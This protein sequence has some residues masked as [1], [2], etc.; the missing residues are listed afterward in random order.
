MQDGS[1]MPNDRLHK[2][3]YTLVAADFFEN[4]HIIFDEHLCHWN[5]RAVPAGG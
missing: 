3:S 1:F 4:I 5:Y 2:T